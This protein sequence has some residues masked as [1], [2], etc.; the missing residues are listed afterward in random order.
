MALRGDRLRDLR[1]RRGL[2]L[3]DLSARL[4]IHS[5][6]ISRYEAGESDPTS[7][8]VARLAKVLGVTSDYLLGLSDDAT[9]NITEDNLSPME[10]K[11]IAAVRDGS[12]REALKAFTALTEGTDQPIIP[13]GQPAVNG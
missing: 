5:R 3:E 6:Q 11:L 4:D 1:Q 13:P 7:D 9:I 10:R 2:T 8:V 12:I